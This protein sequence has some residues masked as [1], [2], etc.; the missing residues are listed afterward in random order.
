MFAF[1]H[2]SDGLSDLSAPIPIFFAIP[3]LSA[4]D[5][6]IPAST[7]PTGPVSVALK[8]RGVGPARSVHFPNFPSSTDTRDGAF[9]DLEH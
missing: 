3:F 8:S 1:D 9:D 2:G 6:H 7:P 4:V 5:L